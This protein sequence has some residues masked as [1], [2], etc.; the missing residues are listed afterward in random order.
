MGIEINPD[1][2][3]GIRERRRK[4]SG[5]ELLEYGR[6]ARQWPIQGAIMERRI[7]AFAVQLEKARAEW[8]RRHPKLH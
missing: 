1:S 4:M 5:A 7:P 3:E 6:A 8:R 2:L